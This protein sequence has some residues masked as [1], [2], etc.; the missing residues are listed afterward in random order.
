MTQ[1][2]A[3]VARDTHGYVLDSLGTRIAGGEFAPGTV[4]TLAGLE[5]EYAVSRTVVREAVRVLESHGMLVSRRR[6]GLT[7]HPIGSWKVLDA[8]VSA[9]RLDSL[10]RETQLAEF[11]ELRSAVEPLAARLAAARASREQRERLVDLADRLVELGHGGQ[12]DSA[13]FLEADIAFHTLLLEASG[14]PLLAGLSGAI[15]SI[16]SGRQGHNLLSGVPAPGTLE[17]HAGTAAGIMESDG[18]KASQA[19]LRLV[20]IVSVEIHQPPGAPLG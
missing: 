5:A 15:A 8:S 12:G 18:D 3:A 10:Q 17:A 7:V 4:L 11:V 6:V 14:N 2:G 13:E 1:T 9:W 20:Q 16:L 19:I